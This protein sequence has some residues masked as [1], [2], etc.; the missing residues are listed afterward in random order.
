MLAIDPSTGRA[1]PELWSLSQAKPNSVSYTATV[2]SYS[3][4]LH[5]LKVSRIQMSAWTL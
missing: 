3:E 5:S 1:N 4:K 2:S